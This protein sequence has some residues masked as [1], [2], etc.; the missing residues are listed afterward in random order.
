MRYNSI[1]SFPINDEQKLKLQKKLQNQICLT[2]YLH[3]PNIVAGVDLAY[4]GERAVAVIVVME[5]HSKRILEVV[6]HVDN[7]AEPYTPGMLAFRELPLILCAWEKVTIEPD[8]V[9]FDGN[10]LMHPRRMGI[11]THASFFLEKP[12]I[13]VAKTYLLG[14]YAAVGEQQGDWERVY[15]QEEEIGAILRTQ[16]GVKPIFVSVGNQMTLVDALRLT[17]AQVGKVS[18]IPEVVRQ[19]DIWTR[20]LRKALG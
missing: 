11:A 13:G 20:K 16:T 9:F 14:Q 3:T 15:D 4:K 7:V 6:Y 8:I 19:A 10:G 1:H 5:Q 17:M 2:P 18:R 12:T